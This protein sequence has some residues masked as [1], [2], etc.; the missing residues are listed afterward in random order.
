M[1]AYIRTEKNILH[2]IVIC[3][4]VYRYRYGIFTFPYSQGD[5]N[6]YRSFMHIFA[7]I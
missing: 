5:N 3:V 2:I 4:C 6:I 1:Y 7:N